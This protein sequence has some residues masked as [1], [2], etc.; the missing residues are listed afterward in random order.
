VKAPTEFWPV[1]HL[2]HTRLEAAGPFHDERL[3]AITDSF[4]RMTPAARRDLLRELR[5]LVAA[6]SDLEPLV[7]VEALHEGHSQQRDWGGVA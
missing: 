5:T 6:L 7:L 3:E 4:A 1:L 2:L